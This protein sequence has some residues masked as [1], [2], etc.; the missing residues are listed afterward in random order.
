MKPATILALLVLLAGTAAADA[1][2]L[3]DGRVLQ[4]KVLEATEDGIRLAFEDGTEVTLPVESIEPNS[5]YSYRR[6]SVDPKDAAGRL[7]LAEYCLEEGLLGQ[8]EGE[9]ALAEAA[10]PGAG[11]R[12]QELAGRLREARAAAI[13]GRARQARARG[14]LEEA[15]RLVKELLVDHDTTRA[16]AE[17]DAE[18]DEIVSALEEERRKEAERRLTQGQG[19]QPGAGQAGP[20]GGQPA[21]LDDATRRKADRILAYA[22]QRLAE[23]RE[24]YRAGLD[25]DGRG[26]VS[27]GDRAYERA[28][29]AFLRALEALGFLSTLT[30]DKTYANA[31]E[32]RVP[33]ARKGL[34]DAFLGLAYLHSAERNWKEASKRVDQALAID[35]TDRH[36]LKLRQ[37]IS[38]E[39]I[40]RS[41]YQ[42]AFGERPPG[43]NK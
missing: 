22:D 30:D 12:A 28:V 18:L 33:A 41:A 37:R 10:D 25:A 9:L 27:E 36:A 20:G 24:A 38:E 29:A 26:V 34:F 2:A 21:P 14:D 43:P 16:A 15:L 6:N 11:P 40:H 8:V 13:L 3:R 35:P 5:Y 4:G 7:A 42:G 1:V 32:E 17:A 23:A 31:V 19:G 39:Y